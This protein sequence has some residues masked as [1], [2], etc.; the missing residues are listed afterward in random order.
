MPLLLLSLQLWAP[1]SGETF[2][3]TFIRDTAILVLGMDAD[4]RRMV[5]QEVTVPTCFILGRLGYKARWFRTPFKRLLFRVSSAFLHSLRFNSSCESWLMLLLLQQ[6]TNWK[7]SFS[8]SPNRSKYL[9]GEKVPLGRSCSHAKSWPKLHSCGSENMK[10][11]GFIAALNLSLILS[12]DFSWATR[13]PSDFRHSSSELQPC[14]DARAFP[15]T[16]A[17]FTFLAVTSSLLKRA[18][19]CLRHGFKNKYSSSIH[20][21][22]NR[23]NTNTSDELWIEF[24]CTPSLVLKWMESRYF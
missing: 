11:S 9:A 8:T 13:P 19:S 14:F 21:T 2:L 15:K 10:S 18:S 6:P 5:P 22:W 12:H 17:D 1:E 24:D 20:K 3:W 23:E 7:S 16:W 4:W